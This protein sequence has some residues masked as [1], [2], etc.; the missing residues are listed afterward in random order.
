M[1]ASIL[2]TYASK[3]GST[4]EIADTIGTALMQHGHQVTVQPV[5]V[6]RD[7]ETYDAVVVGSAVYVG[8]WQKEAA[9]FLE[10]HEGPLKRRDVWLFSSGPTGAGDAADILN[11]WYFPEK[12]QPLADRIQPHDIALFH[13]RLEMKDLNLVERM[14]IKGVKAP[15]GD[16]RN[17]ETIKD[18]ADA[19]NATIRAAEE[20]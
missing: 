9:Q 15:L 18:W 1:S 3:H 2:V 12:L 10:Q 14:M 11:D 19:I 4:A 8:Q 20:A 6:V 17:W 7:I 5:E 16:F 13:G